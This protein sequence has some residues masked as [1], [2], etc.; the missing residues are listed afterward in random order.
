MQTVFAQQS[1]VDGL[2]LL[3][4]KQYN[5]AI[6]VF[7]EILN[8][9][10]TNITAINALAEAQ[11]KLGNTPATLQLYKR[12]LKIQENQPDT[13]L[14]LGNVLYYEKNIKPALAA[15]KSA[16]K[17]SPDFA[18]GHNNLATIYK[19]LD[20]NDLAIVHFEKAIELDDSYSRAMRN[21]GDIYLKKG[22]SVKAIY[23]L[24]RATQTE[25]ESLY[26]LFWLGRA[27]V[28]NGEVK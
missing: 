15:Y 16:V 3:E 24:E 4:E 22:N 12:S 20:E 17:H 5:K 28:Q 10:Q 8:N 21:L 27:H 13:W 23:W 14:A 18:R 7:E 2:K 11:N 9:D 1:I 26:G 6:K 25:P 19:E